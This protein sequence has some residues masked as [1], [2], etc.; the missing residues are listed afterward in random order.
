M[1]F[2]FFIFMGETLFRAI[3]RPVPQI[4]HKIQE[5][6]WAWMMGCWFIGGQISNGLLSTGAFE[7]YVNDALEFSKLK[8]GRMPDLND[9]NTIFANYNV[10]LS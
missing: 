6:K 2:I 9:I 10:R 8:S 7:I 3:N 4:Y 1:G 5:N